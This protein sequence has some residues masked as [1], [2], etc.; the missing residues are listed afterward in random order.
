MQCTEVAA[1]QSNMDLSSASNWSFIQKQY[2]DLPTKHARFQEAC[3]VVR[4]IRKDGL[5]LG[6]ASFSLTAELNQ[7]EE[8]FLLYEVRMP[9]HMRG[10]ASM[11]DLIH[12][13][14]VALDVFYWMCIQ[15][16]MMWWRPAWQ[17]LDAAPFFTH[18]QPWG[19]DD[20]EWRT[21]AIFGCV[22]N[23]I[24]GENMGFYSSV[25]HIGERLRYSDTSSPIN[26]FGFKFIVI[27][28]CREGM[29]TWHHS[30][31]VASM[32]SFREEML[33]SIEEEKLRLDRERMLA[34]CMAFHKR[35]GKGSVADVVDT[36]IAEM[37]IFPM[38][39]GYREGE[40]REPNFVNWMHD[41]E[42]DLS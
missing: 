29:K 36:C 16:Y 11:G 2:Q 40:K 3:R 23:N 35:L 10:T 39:R 14:E 22:R 1:T 28:I 34:F 13:K 38:L 37:F 24:R 33:S 6:T 20:A 8:P 41:L 15:N 31:D 7:L 12:G 4:A 30:F 32:L 21:L 18:H 17:E 19:K 27:R 25:G 9:P 26:Q 5:H 42:S